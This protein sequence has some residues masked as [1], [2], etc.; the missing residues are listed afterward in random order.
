MDNGQAPLSGEVTQA[1]PTVRRAVDG[2]LVPAAALTGGQF[3]DQL[4]DGNF[5]AD[6][7]VTL[8]DLAAKMHEIGTQTGQ[9]T[10]GT[11][12]IKIDLL[13]ED[14]MFRISSDLKVKEPE[15]PR[16][17]SVMWT[18]EHN[19][20]TRFPPNQGQFFGVR[21]VDGTGGGPR[22]V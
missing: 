13:R 10:K 12:T 15:L 21:S 5:S 1:E 14:N 20:F 3:I 22:S 7:H 2:N 8:K 9:K 6:L 18:D 19:R 11:V 16:P 4:E 17:R